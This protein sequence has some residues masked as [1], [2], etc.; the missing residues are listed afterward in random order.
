[1]KRGG[2]LVWAIEVGIQDSSMIRVTFPNQV[3]L[4][5]LLG[6]KA[7]GGQH[8]AI[9]RG[10]KTAPWWGGQPHPRVVTDDELCAII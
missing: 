4:I 8:R 6:Q 3:A 5:R 1:M 7:H 2:P 10:V 9:W